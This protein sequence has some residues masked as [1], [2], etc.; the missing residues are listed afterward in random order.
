M[1]HG[2]SG[3]AGE[4]R[5]RAKRALKT[6]RFVA[7]A[8]AA[9]PALLCYA[10][11]RVYTG[12]SPAEAASCAAAAN[13]GGVGASVVIGLL[14][15]AALGSAVAAVAAGSALDAVHA[16][17]LGQARQR[18]RATAGLL[19]GAV[20]AATMVVLVTVTSGGWRM[21]ASGAPG[22]W[23]AMFTGIDAAVDQLAVA[24]FVAYAA[25]V[26]MAMAAAGRA[27]RR[28]RELAGTD[29]PPYASGSGRT[30]PP[31]GL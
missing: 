9:I 19:A 18:A 20:A 27:A 21:T 10:L 23:D 7:A 5:V 2:M 14:A 26:V 15:A 25:P 30:S 1:L 6:A 8:S 29:Q 3:V 28:L 12:R 16:D 24:A 22:S 31:G 11:L 4:H 17:R 13:C